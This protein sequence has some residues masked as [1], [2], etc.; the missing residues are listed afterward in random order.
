MSS[1]LSSFSQQNMQ[2]FFLPKFVS[3]ESLKIVSNIR[4]KIF[5]SYLKV[6][7]QQRHTGTI[8]PPFTTKLLRL[9]RLIHKQ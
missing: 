9:N 4:Q 7:D 3:L 1:Q 8:K 5:T 2:L 6:V